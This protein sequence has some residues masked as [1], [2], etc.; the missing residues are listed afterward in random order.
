MN[1]FYEEHTDKEVDLDGK[2]IEL[3]FLNFLK[4]FIIDGN[5]IKSIAEQELEIKDLYFYREAVN[6]MVINHQYSLVIDLQHLEYV[7]TD[8]SEVIQHCYYRV[9]N[10]N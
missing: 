1:D 8:L 9:N 7:D 3:K 10:N 5:G 6:E 4:N 2:N